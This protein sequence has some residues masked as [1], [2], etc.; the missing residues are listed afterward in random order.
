MS[1]YKKH[2]FF[3]YDK[4]GNP[5]TK[6][7]SISPLDSIKFMCLSCCNGNAQDVK[8]CD[9]TMCPIFCYKPFSGKINNK[10]CP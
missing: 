4:F 3:H 10:M 9:N 1:I 2:T 6:T 5:G 7:L 8:K